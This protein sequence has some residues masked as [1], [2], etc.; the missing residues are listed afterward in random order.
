[1]DGNCCDVI[2]APRGAHTQASSGVTILAGST[3]NLAL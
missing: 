3:V 1:M 2:D